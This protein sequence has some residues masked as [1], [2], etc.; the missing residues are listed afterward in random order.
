MTKVTPDRETELALVYAG[1]AR[2][3]EGL[4]DADRR[5]NEL[6]AEARRLGGS[7][8]QIARAADMT[9][10]GAHSKWRTTRRPK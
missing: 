9:P 10:Q 8:S 5:R 6:V 4:R 3:T 7:W 1:I 2:M